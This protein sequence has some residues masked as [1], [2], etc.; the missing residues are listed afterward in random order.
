MATTGFL[1]VV[2][3]NKM[4]MNSQQRKKMLLLRLALGLRATSTLMGIYSLIYIRPIISVIGI[5]VIFFTFLQLYFF[6][7]LLL[8]KCKNP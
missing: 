4:T 8:I 7:K 1:P 6:T 3:T 2:A 5:A